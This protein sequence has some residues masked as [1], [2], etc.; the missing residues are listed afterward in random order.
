MALWSRTLWKNS[1]K[2]SL[3]QLVDSSLKMILLNALLHILKRFLLW[4]VWQKVLRSARADA[5]KAVFL[6]TDGFSNGGDPRP[7]ARRL[8][9]QGVKIFTFGIRNGN[10]RELWEMASDPRNETCYV[11]DS[12]EEF[13]ALA[14]RALHSGECL[15][16]IPRKLIPLDTGSGSLSLWK[17]L[18]D[19]ELTLGTLSDVLWNPHFET[20]QIKNSLLLCFLR[21]HH[22]AS[23]IVIEN[24]GLRV[25]RHM[26][27]VVMKIYKYLWTLCPAQAFCLLLLF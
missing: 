11:L 8:R 21:M 16:K 15:I 18:P 23:L 12:F 7:E 9:Q 22:R 10:V 5:Q 27:S 24:L 2:K 4:C 19:V 17:K 14:R 1:L 13:E 20:L 25:E 26:I 6:I 3:L